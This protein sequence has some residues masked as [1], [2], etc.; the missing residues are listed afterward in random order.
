M[1][2]AAS[3]PQPSPE[4]LATAKT[5]RVDAVTAEVLRALTREGME[6]I[7]L[8]GPS[9]AR[10]LY[11]EG[12]LRKYGDSDLLVSAPEA[13]RVETVL[14]RLGF[15]FGRERG[16][17]GRLPEGL[18]W[19]RDDDEVDVHTTLRGALAEPGQQWAV[20]SRH[21]EAITVSGELV[22]SLSEPA[23]TLH[24]ALHAARHG[25]CA[26]R[27]LEDLARGLE[28]LPLDVWRQAA[29]IAV[30][31]DA[32]A[33]FASGLRLTPAGAALAESLGLPDGLS[34]EDALYADSATS[35][36]VG[37]WRLVQTRGVRAK[38]RL[39]LRELF[40]SAEFMRLLAPTTRLGA[41]G[42]LLGYLW[43][44][45]SLAAASPRAIYALFRASRAAR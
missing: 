10:W 20:L 4:I 29:G 3:Q 21:T 34:V 37:L 41:H 13:D 22:R 19:V 16:L 6:P 23:R 28:S 24:L 11:Y 35:I 26:G 30:E 17:R 18:H 33:S 14:V 9:F 12:E 40:P 7:L 15:G 38:A 27:P 1:R 42:L 2:G 44:P 25:R 5:L 45:F 8:K 32:A 31:I 39:V 36:A 43:R